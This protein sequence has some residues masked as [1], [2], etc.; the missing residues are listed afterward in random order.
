MII[1][2][3]S[4]I[5]VGDVGEIFAP[6]FLHKDQTPKDLSGCTISMKLELLTDISSGVPIGTLKTCSGT[7]VIDDAVN[8]KAHYQYQAWDVDTPGIWGR[9]V[10]ITDA[11]GNPVHGDDGAGG[12]KKLMILPAK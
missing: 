3:D 6:Q 2:D 4:P 10:K 1:E 9:W 8:G 12:P 7:W 5:Y 11:S